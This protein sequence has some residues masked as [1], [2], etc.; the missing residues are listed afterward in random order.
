M[1][2]LNFHRDCLEVKHDVE[3]LK[4]PGLVPWDPVNWPVMAALFGI[5]YLVAFELLFRVGYSLRRLRGLYFWSLIAGSFGCITHITGSMV[6][7]FVA[8]VPWTAPTL[9]I[10]FGWLTMVGGQSLVLYSRIYLVVR[11]KSTIWAIRA[12]I[13]VTFAVCFGAGT[14]ALILVNVT[15]GEDPHVAW[16]FFIIER[17]QLCAFLWCEATLSVI[18]VFATWRVLRSNA[19]LRVKRV[20]KFLI[21]TNLVI[22]L[23]DCLVLC[24]QFLNWY[25]IQ[26]TLKPAVYAVKLKLEFAFLN[27]L[28]YITN[29]G[30]SFI[31]DPR[32]PSVAPDTEKK[33]DSKHDSYGKIALSADLGLWRQRR[34]DTQSTDPAISENQNSSSESRPSPAESRSSKDGDSSNPVPPMPPL[35]H[36]TRTSYESDAIQH[37]TWEGEWRDDLRNHSI[38]TRIESA[39][40]PKRSTLSAIDKR[41]SGEYF[42]QLNDPASRAEIGLRDFGASASRSGSC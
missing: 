34:R 23:L 32:K 39:V 16:A 36:Q 30:F 28:F 17:S 12:M 21:I 5:C 35:P 41:E 29:Q 7:F 31:R 38:I 37:S 14:V 3:Y 25:A 42:V 6:K 26:A 9:L 15:H 10:V 20:V 8:G 22:L 4:G 13:A 18:Y 11:D 40:V 19:V 1:G 24:M 33:R 27:Q 2:T